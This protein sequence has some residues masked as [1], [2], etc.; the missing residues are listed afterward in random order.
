MKL[1]LLYRL[2]LFALIMTSLLIVDA[3]ASSSTT[4]A[5][6]CKKTKAKIEH[7]QKKMR[8]GYTASQSVKY[9]KTLNKL[10]KEEFKYCF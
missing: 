8:R 3:N 10:Y 9:H 5:K 1:S 2:P 4:K 6:Q 7:I